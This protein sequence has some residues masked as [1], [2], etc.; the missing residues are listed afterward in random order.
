MKTNKPVRGST[1]PL[2]NI[3]S[4]KGTKVIFCFP[5]SGYEYQQQ[6][7]QKHLVIGNIYTVSRTEVYPSST[8]VYFE[9]T[10]DIAFNSVFFGDLDSVVQNF[11]AKLN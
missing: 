5:N 9:E 11:L 7:A 6:D 2:M 10:G 3:Y 8:N 4:P 1:L